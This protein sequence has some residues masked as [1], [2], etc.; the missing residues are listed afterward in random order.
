M[1]EIKGETALDTDIKRAKE[2]LREVTAELIEENRDE[3]IR[4][5]EARLEQERAAAQ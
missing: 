1:G 5:V 4:R 2:L 3:L